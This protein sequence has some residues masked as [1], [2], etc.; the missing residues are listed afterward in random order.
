[1]FMTSMAV[2]DLAA[3]PLIGLIELYERHLLG[4]PR[5]F[6]HLFSPKSI[7]VFNVYLVCPRKRAF[8]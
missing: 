2:C 8:E 6:H 4:V 1:M 3:C 7:C 5:L